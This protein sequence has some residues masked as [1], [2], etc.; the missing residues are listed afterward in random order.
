VK[1]GAG[2]KTSTSLVR[3]TELRQVSAK[4]AAQPG[5]SR[6]PEPAVPAA[7]RKRLAERSGGICEAQLTGCLWYAADPAHRITR[8][9]GGRHGKAKTRHDA[10]SNLLHLCR[11]CHNWSGVRPVEAGQGELGIVLKERHDPLAEPVVYRG[12]L[13]YLTNDGRVIPFAD[14]QVAA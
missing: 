9:N 4:R 14:R 2:V 10:L 7:V 13:S 8:K 1:R 11:P 3:R 5:K 12:A 6:R